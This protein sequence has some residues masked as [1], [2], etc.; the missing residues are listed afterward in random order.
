MLM[1]NS[2]GGKTCLISSLRASGSGLYWEI[3]S[4]VRG[5]VEFANKVILLRMRGDSST[6]K[7]R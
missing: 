6:S 4:C 7:E 3:C 1:S 5:K 2:G